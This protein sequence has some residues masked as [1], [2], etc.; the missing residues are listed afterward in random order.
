[1]KNLVNDLL[2]DLC[3]EKCNDF[4]FVIM[5][6]SCLYLRN[7]SNVISPPNSLKLSCC[8]L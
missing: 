8:L 7:E 5:F 6:V 1:M 2:V 3:S 4:D